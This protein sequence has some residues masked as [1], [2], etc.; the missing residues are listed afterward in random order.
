MPNLCHQRQTIR[1]RVRCNTLPW[2]ILHWRGRGASNPQPSDRQTAGATC[3]KRGFSRFSALFGGLR[4]S[5]PRR[6]VALE[7]PNCGNSG[8][9]YKP[10][11]NG[12]VGMSWRPWSISDP[13]LHSRPVPCARTW[14]RVSGAPCSSSRTSQGRGVILRSV[15]PRSFRLCL[16]SA[17]CRPHIAFGL[18]W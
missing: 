10:C 4:G 14:P 3:E 7:G 8:V 11:Y 16:K 13:S 15:P 9:C 2:L 18:P 17:I 12:R 1:A 6:R 5:G